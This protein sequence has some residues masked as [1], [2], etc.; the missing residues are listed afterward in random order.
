M[1]ISMIPRSTS[2][3]LANPGSV[4]REE[5]L[6][7]LRDWR[8]RVHE[9]YDD[10]EGELRGTSF[11]CDRT[12]KHTPDEEFP[13]RVGVHDSEQPPIDILRIV[14]P[15]NSTAAVMIP[16]G[17]WVIG[18]NGQ[19]DLRIR[20]VIGGTQTYKLLDHSAPFSRPV[21]WTLTLGGYPFD[22]QPFDPRWLATKLQ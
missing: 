3:E 17:L 22:R 11:R 12:T 21:H 10:I 7:R 13:R 19:V 2:E 15:D 14:R 9:L 20:P 18:A 8:D 5:A 16:R 1:S 4:S 6:E